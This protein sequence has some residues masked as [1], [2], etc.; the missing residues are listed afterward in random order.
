[1]AEAKKLTSPSQP[2]Q[3]KAKNQNEMHPRPELGLKSVAEESEYAN[4]NPGMQ[5][6]AGQ[7]ATQCG[8]N[9]N[10]QGAP[11]TPPVPNNEAPMSLGK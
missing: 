6:A 7:K 3:K 4:E 11:A 2:D 10:P 8:G 1:M 9:Q 5:E